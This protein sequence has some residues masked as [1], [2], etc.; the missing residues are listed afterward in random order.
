MFLDLLD[1]SDITF[2]ESSERDESLSELLEVMC[3]K[4]PAINREAS[5]EALI[6]REDKMS[7]VVRNGTAVPHAVFKDDTETCIALGISKRGVDFDESSPEKSSVHIIIEIMFEQKNTEAHLEVLKDVLLL[8]EKPDFF[9]TLV[10][11][12]TPA[13]AF[14]Y[15]ESLK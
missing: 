7:T 4:H 15:L 10:Q 5:L 9:T 6:T 3:R 14:R 13:D 8:T 12:E 1:L 11:C 2:L